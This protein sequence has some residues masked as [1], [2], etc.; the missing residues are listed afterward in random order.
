MDKT[1]LRNAHRAAGTPLPI[2]GTCLKLWTRSAIR[3]ALYRVYTD[4][5]SSVRRLRP[6]ALDT[7]P[8]GL[9]TSS[10]LTDAIRERLSSDESPVGAVGGGALVRVDPVRDAWV[11]MLLPYFAD[12]GCFFT[13]TYRDDYGYPHGLMKPDNVLRDFK[14][15]LSVEDFGRA[16][17]V[18]AEPHQ[19]RSI[20]HC[21]ALLAEC[22]DSD[23]DGLQAAWTETRG[24][25]SAPSLHD[26]GVNYVTKYAMKSGD[27]VLFD[28]CLS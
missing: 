13:G 18:C 25:C 27:A 20:W 16:F 12:D 5:P 2:R 15:F 17:V 3:D 9:V 1:K 14:R 24:W 22:S 11:E 19:E 26:G 10:P 8:S 4:T 6:W 7:R 23:R 21:H 28:W